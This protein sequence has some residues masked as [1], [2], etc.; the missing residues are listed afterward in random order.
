MIS[1]YDRELVKV[2]C[3]ERNWSS[4]GV[5]SEFSGRNLS[6]KTSVGWMLKKTSLANRQ[7]SIRDQFARQNFGKHR[8]CGGAHSQS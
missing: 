3:Q 5:L 6:R 8:T 7:S 2:L 1:K 4:Q